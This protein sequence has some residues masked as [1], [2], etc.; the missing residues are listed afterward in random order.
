VPVPVGV[1]VGVLVG[2]VGVIVGVMVGVPVGVTVTVAVAVGDGDFDGVAVGVVVPTLAAF[3]NCSTGLPAS[4]AFIICC[5]ISAGSVPPKTSPIPAPSTVWVGST[6]PIHT[7]VHSCGV[8]PVNQALVLLS[9]VP[10]LP[11][12]GR[13]V[14]ARPKAVPPGPS[15]FV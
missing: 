10:V 2:V 12:A 15:T 1:V 11:A 4:G 7:D 5:Q 14:S 13:P 9:V 8:K 3:G 6:L